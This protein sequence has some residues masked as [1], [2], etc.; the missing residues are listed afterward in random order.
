[1]RPPAEVL[2]LILGAG[3]LAPS[4]E[5]YHYL[6]FR[7]LEE[8]VELLT[9][10]HDSWRALPHRRMLGLMALGAVIENMALRSQ[11]LGLE[12]RSSLFPDA[13]RLDLVAALDWSRGFPRHDPLDAQIELRHTNRRFYSRAAIDAGILQELQTAASAQGGCTLVWMDSPRQRQ[14]A[15]SVIRVAETERFRRRSLHQELF[16]AIRFEAGWEQTTDE[17]LPPVALEVEPPMRGAFKLLRDW[18][19]M[20]ASVWVGAHWGLG[21][22]AG[23]LPCALSPHIGVLMAHDDDPRIESVIAGRAFERVWLAATAEGLALQPYAAPAVL[24]TQQSGE[25]WVSAA[26]KAQVGHALADLTSGHSGRPHMFFRI[27]RASAP[28]GVTRR[29]TLHHYVR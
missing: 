5:N 9:T 17:W 6:C 28:T 14:R 16:G 27:G 4:A 22:R 10:D 18:R 1:M 24:A 25:G 8:S 23:Y 26:T 12:M 21:F 29:K 7:V 15:L 13:S 2:R 11:T 20:R 19:V 3:V